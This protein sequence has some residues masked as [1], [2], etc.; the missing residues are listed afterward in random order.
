MT[1]TFTTHFRFGLPDFLSGPWHEDWYNLVHAIDRALYEVVI[2]AG[3]TIWANS[4][5]YTIGSIVI[6]PIDGT[7]WSAQVAHTSTATP[8]TFD[9]ERIANPTFWNTLAATTADDVEFTPGGTLSSTNVQD[10]IEELLAETQPVDSDLTAVAGLATAGYAVRVSAGIW[11]IRTLVAPAAGL[12]ISNPVGTAGDSAF[13]LANDLAAL[14]ALASAGFAARTAS[15]TWAVRTL[16][17]P[18]AGI[19]ITNPAG[20]AGDPTLVLADDLAAVEGLAATGLTA[21]VG[22]SSWT[23]RSLIAPAAG[24]T[25]SNNDGVSGNPTLVLADDLAG[26]EAMSGTGLVARTAS[27]TYAQRTLQSA[28]AGLTWTDGNGIAGNPVPVFANDLAALEALSSSG[29]PARTG[30][31]AWS[32]RTWANATAGLSWTNPAGT[33]G[34]PT[35]V[36]A[37]DLAALEG[38]GSTGFAVRTT[39]DTWA[40]R[41]L[42]GTANRVTITNTAG[43]AG[44]PVFNT[45]TDVLHINVTATVSVGYTVTPNNLGTMSN[46]TINPALGNY[47]FGT[48]DGA[49]TLTAPASDCAIDL[50]VTNGA[51]AGTITLSGFTAPAG[52]G[53]DTYA[54]TNTNK[55]ILHIRRI[56]GTA[57]YMWKALQ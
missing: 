21:R 37:N 34:N 17:A 3:G 54:T 42:T 41:T 55:Y 49:F 57:T 51:S 40:Q 45:G 19:T 56:N 50:L 44:D 23:V 8:T 27:N 48:N 20:T 6:S 13:S 53:G 12:A 11:A 2:V 35:P 15:D 47:Q 1:T 26:L 5:V 22:V 36:L 10:A 33:A 52:G 9:Q 39:T 18:A 43:V 7:L 30:T 16:V 46:F 25:I 31:D 4:T 32:I 28:S 24:I 14:E 38:L 29:F